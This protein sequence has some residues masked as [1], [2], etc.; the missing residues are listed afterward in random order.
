MARVDVWVSE[1]YESF[2]AGL[3]HTNVLPLAGRP[4][5]MITIR[6]E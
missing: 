6:P 4:T 1:S 2:Q 5:V 3:G